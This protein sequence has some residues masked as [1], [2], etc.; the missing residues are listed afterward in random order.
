MKLKQEK[1]SVTLFVLVAMLLFCVILLLAYMNISNRNTEQISNLRK[2]Q[3]EYSQSQKSIDEIYENTINTLED[4][5][6]I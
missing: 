5:S 6:N 1:G 3:S 4:E 2:I